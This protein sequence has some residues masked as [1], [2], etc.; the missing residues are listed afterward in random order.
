MQQYREMD[1][2][3]CFRFIHIIVLVDIL[4]HTSELKEDYNENA[5]EIHEI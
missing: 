4:Y 1:T 3:V 2:P 5:S